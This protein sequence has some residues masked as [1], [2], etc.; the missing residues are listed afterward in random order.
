MFW[1]HLSQPQAALLAAAIAA[2]GAIIGGSV[3]SL[4]T[5]MLNGRANR[6]RQWD[7]IRHTAYARVTETFQAAL[8]LYD[9]TGRLRADLATQRRPPRPVGLLHRRPLPH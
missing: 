1:S 9:D 8:G 2:T 7:E 6:R 5:Q 3:A 4:L